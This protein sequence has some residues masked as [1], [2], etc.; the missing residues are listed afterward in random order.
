MD[1]NLSKRK[2]CNNRKNEKH[3]APLFSEGNSVDDAISISSTEES[4]ENDYALK[5][6]YRHLTK[7]IPY[8]TGVK[9]RDVKNL[10]DCKNFNYIWNAMQNNKNYAPPADIRPE[11]YQKWKSEK[12]LLIEEVDRSTLVTK[13][14][15]VLETHSNQNKAQYGTLL[16]NGVNLLVKNVLNIGEEDVVLDIGS[17]TGRVLFQLASTTPCRAAI[18]IEIDPERC[19]VSYFFKEWFESYLILVSEGKSKRMDQTAKFFQ[20]CVDIRQGNLTDPAYRELLM[21]A[22]VLYCNN[23]NG[24]F[25]ARTETATGNTLDFHV[26]SIFAGTKPGTRLVSFES[27]NEHLGDDCT[28]LNKNI[29]ERHRDGGFEQT[30]DASFFEYEE[31]E[32]G[33]IHL[34]SW[35][36]DS[37]KRLYV[38]LYTRT[39]QT[40][41]HPLWIGCRNPDCEGQMHP[42]A[43][44]NEETG[45]LDRTC[46]YCEE[47]MRMSTTR[48]VRQKR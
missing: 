29:L 33:S 44:L 22:T 47:N 32:L 14:N 46:A 35:G 48:S 28:L 30:C 7:V 9:S 5:R 2:T 42:T 31:I 37:T 10:L 4:S 27:L 25:G 43:A 1:N 19:D 36:G 24:I 3:A 6:Q 8:P 23:F 39:E 16:P 26:A 17:G 34:A 41:S 38:H 18:G 20:Q 13:A 12:K 45:L 40:H 21:S 11:L 15:H